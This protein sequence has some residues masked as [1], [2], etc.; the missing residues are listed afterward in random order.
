MKCLFTALLMPR[1]F[2]VEGHDLHPLAVRSTPVRF[3]V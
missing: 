2:P 1:L 3:G